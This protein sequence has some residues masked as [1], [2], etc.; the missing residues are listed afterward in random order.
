MD[1]YE[2][3][4]IC[5]QYLKNYGYE[6]FSNAKCIEEPIVL[7]IILTKK[8]LVCGIPLQVC[9]INELSTL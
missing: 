9:G 3:V 1:Q 8:F 7:H 2:I 6:S 5:L 4:S